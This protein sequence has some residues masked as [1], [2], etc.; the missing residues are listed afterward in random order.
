MAGYRKDLYAYDADTRQFTLN[1]N[2][3]NSGIPS[4]QTTFIS[5]YTPRYLL[6]ARQQYADMVHGLNQKNQNEVDNFNNN[7]LKE[8]SQYGR[9]YDSIVANVNDQRLYEG[10]TDLLFYNVGKIYN[11]NKIDF[12]QLSENLDDAPSSVSKSDSTKRNLAQQTKINKKFAAAER[13]GISVT[14][15]NEV[16]ANI[17]S[18][19]QANPTDSQV[20]QAIQ[21]VKSSPPNAPPLAS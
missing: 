5:K 16:K 12:K 8:L 14:Q 6:E 18:K 13:Y 7:L 11:Q 19:N 3:T 21:E 2:I 20:Q 10:R 15:Y 1:P 9:N 4:T 17:Q